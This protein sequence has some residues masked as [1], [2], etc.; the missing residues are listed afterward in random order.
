MMPSRAFLLALVMTATGAA[1]AMAQASPPQCNDFMKLRAEAEQRAGAIRT[2]S[3]R[4][5]EPKELCP[6]FQRFVAV[7]NSMVKF[8][9]DNKV[10]C[11]VPDQ[12]IK[13][14]KQEH[15]RSAKLRTAVCNGAA[16]GEAGPRPKP[17]SLSDALGGT[18]IDTRDNTKT[19]RGTFDTL[20]GSPL[21]R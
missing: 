13:N 12:A 15:D 6:L 10:W 5:A 9:V 16:G 21:G 4:K 2:A 1:A 18:S 14:V 7:E 17:P 19:G 11:G 20:T 8:L 3:Q